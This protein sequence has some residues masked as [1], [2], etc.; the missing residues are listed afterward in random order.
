MMTLIVRLWVQTCNGKQFRLLNT[1]A[2][3]VGTGMEREIV[4]CIWCCDYGKDASELL[5][6]FHLK[7]L[8]FVSDEDEFANTEDWISHGIDIY[9]LKK[10]QRSSYSTWIHHTSNRQSGDTC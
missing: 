7:K 8:L 1:E 2:P 5:N 3:I 6:M 10:F 4:E 9:H